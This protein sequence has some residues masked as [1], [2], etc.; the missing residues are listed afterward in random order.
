M[1][2]EAELEAANEQKSQKSQKPPGLADSIYANPSSTLAGEYTESPWPRRPQG[3]N[4]G[5]FEQGGNMPLWMTQLG[6]GRS[7]GG[8]RQYE[9]SWSKPKLPIQPKPKETRSVAAGNG[10]TNNVET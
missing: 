4:K 5:R 9:G 8:W 6:A 10:P 3:R 7:Q 1:I 2:E